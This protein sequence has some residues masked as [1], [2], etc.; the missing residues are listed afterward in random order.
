[1]LIASTTGDRCPIRLLSGEANLQ[2]ALPGCAYAGNTPAQA[3]SESQA[4]TTVPLWVY[5]TS[6]TVDDNIY[7]GMI[8]G[9]AP[10]TPDLTR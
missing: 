5:Q 6:T 4:G 8:M 10:G 2:A 9:N 3:L 7:T 1:M